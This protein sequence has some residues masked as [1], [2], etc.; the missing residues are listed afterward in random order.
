MQ[1]KV[2]GIHAA[3]SLLKFKPQTIKELFV[4][5]DRNDDRVS[6]IIAEAKTLAIDRK[7][8]V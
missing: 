6:N 4:N 8:V 1:H 3:T 5:L 2:Y 7:S